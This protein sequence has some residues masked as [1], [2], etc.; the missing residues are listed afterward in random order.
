VLIKKKEGDQ[1][2]RE[3]M[4]VWLPRKK[5]NQKDKDLAEESH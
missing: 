1:N 3:G 5:Q 4:I 2:V